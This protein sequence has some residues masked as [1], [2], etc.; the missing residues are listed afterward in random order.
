MQN[1]TTLRIRAFTSL[2]GAATLAPALTLSPV[3]VAQDASTTQGPAASFP[4]SF[5]ERWKKMGTLYE[6]A[7]NPLV[8]KFKVFGRLHYQYG[9]LDGTTA[10]Q[11]FTYDADQIRR[12]RTGIGGNFLDHL[13]LYAEAEIGN[14]RR[15]RGGDFN[16]RF[17]HMWQFKVHF[18]AKKAFDLD[19]LDMFKIGVGSREINMSYEWVTSSKR[20]KTV[21]RSAIANK[22][23]A[24]NSEFANPT[25]V[26]T[27]LGLDPVE[28]TLGVFSTTQDDWIAP[29]DD[30][31]LYY[32][33]MKWDLREGEGSDTDLRLAAFYQDVS[34]D[35]EVLAA[36]V[37]WTTALS[38][39]HKTGPWELH[40]EGVV[41]D[42]GDQSNAAREGDFWGLVFMPSYWILE[43]SLEAAFQIQ[44]QGASE[45]EGI[46][47][48]SRYARRAGVRDGIPSVENGRGDEQLTF[49]AGLN[50]LLCGHQHKVMIGVEYDTL[51]SE[52]DEI[53]RGWMA[54]V[55]YRTYW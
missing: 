21:E 26:W 10:G 19:G 1:A 25:G 6:D 33:K 18:D 39:Q 54:F 52:G 32:T 5:C 43:D 20:I 37:E 7:D 53:Y 36:G 3:A 4:P 23:W 51:S 38:L 13:D 16:I 55:A 50:K 14:D 17:Q 42:N 29:F 2:L 41:G 8:Q 24:Y 30:G 15:P 45:S 47:L 35:E 28:W 49:Y 44:Y 11:D 34:V 31:E 22:I 12:F 40:V 27:E 9:T 48:N 46:R